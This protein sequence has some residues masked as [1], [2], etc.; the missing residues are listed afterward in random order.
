MKIIID[1][2]EENFFVVELENKEMINI[3]KSIIPTNA[4]VGDVISI[5]VDVNETEERKEKIINLMNEL[6]ED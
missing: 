5:E 2:I 3:P 1:R 6:W 4:K